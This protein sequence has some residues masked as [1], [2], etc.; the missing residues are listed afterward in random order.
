MSNSNAASLGCTVHPSQELDDRKKMV[1]MEKRCFLHREGEKR[2]RTG[3]TS[4]NRAL[5]HQKM[6]SSISVKEAADAL[7]GCYQKMTKESCFLTTINLLSNL[8]P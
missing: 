3:I 6:A 1:K 4:V 5:S 8:W 7:S 2:K